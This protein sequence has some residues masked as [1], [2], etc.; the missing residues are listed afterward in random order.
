MR[1]GDILCDPSDLAEE[2]VDD[3]F[4]FAFEFLVEFC[5]VGGA[6]AGWHAAAYGA[7]G[8]GGAG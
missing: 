5:D 6:V 7:G 2:T 3:A 4:L 1:G 8:G